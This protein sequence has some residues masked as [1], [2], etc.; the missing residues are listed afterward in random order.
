MDGTDA[1]ATKG[2]EQSRQ[3]GDRSD[4]WRRGGYGREELVTALLARGVAGEDC[5]HDRPNVLWKIKRVVEGDP[6]A[7]FGIEGLSGAHSREE[8]LRFIAEDAGF[9]PDPGL[10]TGPVPIDPWRML[11]ALEAAGDRLAVAAERG[12]HVILATGH[13][14]GLVLLYMAVGDL[15]VTHGAK[16]LRP[17]EGVSWLDEGHHKRIRYLHGVAVLSWGGS[18]M[19]THSPDPM[20]RMLDEV[21]PDLVFADHGFAGAAI[22]AGIETISIVDVNDPAP[23]VAKRQGRTRHVVVMDDN[24]EP[25]DYW[26]CFQA[27]ASRFPSSAR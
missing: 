6:D 24:V 27:I 5:S 7:Q 23:V 16:L 18:S 19:H 1:Q 11:D 9:S 12:E 15:L 8:V 2:Y 26:P 10:T 4:R 21:R 25:E 3:G 20:K 17:L 22:Q 14:A 13:P